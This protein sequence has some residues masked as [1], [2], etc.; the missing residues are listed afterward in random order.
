MFSIK[1]PLLKSKLASN[2][3]FTF[4]FDVANNMRNR[5]FWRDADTLN[6]C[7]PASYAPPI[8]QPLSC[9]PI[10]VVFI[11]TSFVTGHISASGAFWYEHHIVFAVPMCVGRTFI[12]WHR[13]FLLISWSKFEGYSD[14]CLGQTYANPPGIAGG[15]PWD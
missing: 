10:H 4:P 11:P 9:L 14:R 8:F 15:L 13:S 12:V 1:V 5:I 3:N 6:R 2:G 7:D